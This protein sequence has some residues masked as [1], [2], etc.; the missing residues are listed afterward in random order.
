MTKNEYTL[1]QKTK[2]GK[3]VWCVYFRDENGIRLNPIYVSKLKK[4]VYKGRDRNKPIPIDPYDPSIGREEC[5]RICEKSLKHDNT[6]DYIFHKNDISPNFIEMVRKVWDYDNSPYIKGRLLEG[7]TIERTT[8]KGYLK[9][10]NDFVVPLIPKDLTLKDIEY[11]KGRKLGEIRER[12][13]LNV[14]DKSYST[15][16]KGLQ[17]MRT[18]LEYCCSKS[19]ID[20]DYKEKLK[21]FPTDTDNGNDPLTI[22]EVNKI[23]SYFYTHTQKGTW[24]R[25]KYLVC[26]LGSTTGLRPSEIIGLKREDIHFID[27]RNKCGVIYVRHGINRDNEYS[28]RKN[29][30]SVYVSTYI[31]LVKEI[32]EF[33][34]LNPDGYDWCFWDRNHTEDHL[35][36]DQVGGVLQ[37]CLSN[38]GINT[39]GRKISFY[40]LRKT[41]ATIIGNYRSYKHKKSSL[42]LDHKETTTTEEYYIK[43]TKES[44]IDCF[45]EIRQYIKLPN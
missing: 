8:C 3:K 2:D 19:L 37:S 20:Q 23:N 32:I 10:F 31:P 45:K 44:S 27:N 12:L 36:R 40:S 24:E 17:S 25:Y 1:F 35:T 26:L 39:E 15:R 33:S 29:K 22:E 5:V 6:I 21:N 4:M 43:N 11:S 16:N 42:L 9:P 14:Q 28:T 38:I 41:A 18:T 7:K 34:E 13:L 30:R